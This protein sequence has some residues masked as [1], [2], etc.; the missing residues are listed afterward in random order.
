DR[1][2]HIVTMTSELPGVYARTYHPTSSEHVNDD[3]GQKTAEHDHDQPATP[4]NDM[5]E[6]TDQLLETQRPDN[7]D[8]EENTVRLNKNTQ[9]SPAD[10]A[11][12][13]PGPDMAPASRREARVQRGSFLPPTSP[14][15]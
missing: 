9:A 11:P 5:T 4:A 13:Q 2:G 3:A 8:H 12:R 14:D 10:S 1:T 15:A 7:T 6:F